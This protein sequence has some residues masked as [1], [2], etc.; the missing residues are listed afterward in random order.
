MEYSPS[1]SENN[2]TQESE[3]GVGY[4]ATPER[5][6]IDE[7][8]GEQIRDPYRWLEDETKPEVYAWA[9][10]QN[11]FRKNYLESID[12]ETVYQEILREQDVFIR[13][14]PFRRGE[15]YFWWERQPG[16]QHHVLFSA[17][18]PDTEEDK[19]M[20]FDVNELSEDGSIADSFF[21]ISR[22]GSYGVYGLMEGGDERDRVFIKNLRSGQESEFY[23][24]RTFT[25]NWRDDESGFY[26]SRSNYE[27]YGGDPSDETHYQQV[28]F[29][30][31]GDNREDDRLIFNAV[32]YL[33]KDASVA[34]HESEDGH[35]VAIN[36]SLG[37][38]GNEQHVYL[39]DVDNEEIKE[40]VPE[41]ESH[42]R[43]QLLGGYVYLYTDHEAHN[44]R[45]LRTT[46][47]NAEAPVDD[48]EEFLGEDPQRQL[49]GWAPTKKEILAIYTY[50]A[51]DQVDRYSQQDGSY[52]DSLDIPELASVGGL[53][54]NRDD[55]DFY[56]TVNTFF[57]PS[58][59]YYFNPE[60]G[61]SELFYEDPRSLDREKY[62]AQQRWY[63]SK[64]GEKIPMFFIAPRNYSESVN[65]PVLLTGYGGFNLQTQPGFVGS[66]KPWLQR[67]GTIART[68]LRGGGEFG[69]AWHE[70][71]M[72]ENKQN[73]FNDFIAA[74]E[75][76][77]E[78]NITRPE[79]IAIKG[80]SNG[81]LLVGASITQRP[82]LFKAAVCAVPLL[83][84]YRY[85]K[86][87]MARRWTHEYGHPENKQEFEWL[88]R[89]SPY[90]H[91]DSQQKYPDTLFTAGMNDTRVHP[92]HAW[93]M[94]AKLQNGHP[95][96]I[97]LLRTEMAAGHGPG[98]G[99]YDAL[100]DFAEELAFIMH[101]LGIDI[102]ADV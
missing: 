79:K 67:G 91:V 66:L 32:D 8:H 48:W 46:P 35:F 18:N 81:G 89:Y 33:P 38:G 74:A 102:K 62:T 86:F 68:N 61:A 1:E 69:E 39:Y 97:A 44:H 23:Y 9:E 101:R 52:I 19:K 98:K 88:K 57:S 13:S 60:T 76:L 24:G 58:T 72:G 96:N 59:H 27:D 95:D 53:R 40:L 99:F 49:Y 31:I 82:D 73:T 42:A 11:E 28:Y 65:N 87:L 83:D 80:G 47:E 3:A 78:E 84:M 15:R 36:A 93:K 63:T 70:A 16:Q 54:T 90:H 12:T 56:Y 17:V 22:H 100:H 10:A 85:H 55:G 50:N 4:P 26:Y 14:S 25:M 34:A 92:L 77:V 94:A 2:E 64:D 21:R 29:H 41:I 7:M 45:I 71:G 5:E 37:S 51:V 43:V 20:V 75:H 30:K 6:V